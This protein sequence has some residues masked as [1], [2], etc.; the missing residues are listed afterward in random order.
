MSML[1]L[2]LLKKAQLAQTHQLM[3]V[4]LVVQVEHLSA[5][6]CQLLWKA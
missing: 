5:T 4:D 6:H 2:Q 3:P 1:M